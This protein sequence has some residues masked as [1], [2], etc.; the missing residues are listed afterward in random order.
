[1]KPFLSNELPGAY[2]GTPIE[3]LYDYHNHNII[4]DDEYHSARLLVG[5]CMDNRKQLKV[6]KNFAYII[7]TG[8][9][10]LR[11]NEL[12]VSLVIAV[13]G[14]KHIVLIGH[15]QCGMVNL[16]AKKG[17]FIE[18][19]VQNAGWDR[20]SAREHFECNIS[21]FEINN[22]KDF[23]LSEAKRLRLKYPNV[24]VAPMMYLIG[25]DRL[26]FVREE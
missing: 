14:V 18:G 21:S 7:R 11:Y 20:E 22:E 23:V 13:H 19:L 3:L 5:M 25:D 17:V 24:I 16:N 8:G 2:S 15:D 6:P 1:M 26:Y 4:H 9:G 10:N 12:Q